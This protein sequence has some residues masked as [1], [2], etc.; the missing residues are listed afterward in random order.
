MQNQIAKI[1]LGMLLL[2][3]ATWGLA[4]TD[5]SQ[6]FSGIGARLKI[7]EGSV[8]LEQVFQGSPA[9]EAGLK[10]GEKILEVEGAFRDS[11]ASNR[12]LE[13]SVLLRSL[14]SLKNQHY[15]NQRVS[16]C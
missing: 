8:R 16:E 11:I 7:S 9:E 14:D 12:E 5:S 13:Y 3:V 2:C 15:L 6:Q 10:R 4:G 1:L